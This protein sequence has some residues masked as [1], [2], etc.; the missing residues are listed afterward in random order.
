MGLYEKPWGNRTLYLDPA[1]IE[2]QFCAI[3]RP[4]S[5]IYA[6][7]NKNNEGMKAPS[8]FTLPLTRSTA[9]IAR[10][11]VYESF[12]EPDDDEVERWSRTGL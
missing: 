7:V 4:P 2:P 1:S 3:P 10:T 5:E 11:S 8:S 6:I 12:G 9:S